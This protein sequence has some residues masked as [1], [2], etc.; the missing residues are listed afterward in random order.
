MIASVWPSWGTDKTL[1]TA[2]A[3]GSTVNYL[4]SFII[5]W[6]YSLPFIWF[7]VHKIR[8]LF[9]VKAFV[10]PAGGITLFIW[11]LVRAGGV[12]PIVHQRA[13]AHGSELAWGVI[14]GIMAAV[15]NFAT[16]IVNDPDFTRFASTPSAAFLPQLI[17]IPL[18]YGLTSFIGIIAGSSSV[19][20][21][22]DKGATWNP[23]DLLKHFITDGREGGVGSVGDRIGTFLIAA[24]F[25]VAQLGTNIAA[26]SISAGTDLT[27]MMPRYLNIRRGGYVCAIVGLCIC[28]WQF[29][30]SASNLTTY[31]SA[32]SVFLSSI[33][34]PMIVDYYIVRKGY[35]QVP[36]LYNAEEDGPYYGVGGFNWHGYASYICGVLI[37]VVGFAGAVGAEVPIGATYIY[38]LNFFTGFIVSGVVYYMLAWLKPISA[39][40]PT[41]KWYEMGDEAQNQELVY[42][43]G[44]D[45]AMSRKS[46]VEIGSVQEDS[47]KRWWVHQK[48]LWRWLIGDRREERQSKGDE[49]ENVP[50]MELNEQGQEVEESV[51]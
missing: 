18:G 33:A 43:A 19:V 7:P 32:Y 25:I 38:R 28:P 4:I 1:T 46:S 40:S 36:D 16:L 48:R 12:G 21:Y 15:S 5:F 31:L 3:M 27:A 17:T 50:L 49:R 45:G 6:L 23:L 20:I 35:Y 51:Y 34:G 22:P 39:L 37:N 14:A 11:C 9:T 8:H 30:T 44:V 10:A 41:G 2:I 26:N 42:S 29:L 24:S 13:S 47:E